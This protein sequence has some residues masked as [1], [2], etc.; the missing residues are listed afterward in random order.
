MI[1][2]IIAFLFF[3]YLVGLH[4]SIAIMEMASWTIA[5]LIL[6]WKIRS[7]EP[8]WFT[9]WRP[10]LA[11]TSVVG[12][13]LLMNPEGRPYID[14]IGFMRWILLM[15]FLSWAFD[16]VWNDAFERR[17][18]SFWVVAL[19]V[20]TSYAVFQC[21]TG[22]D[23]IR[24]QKEVLDPVG[25]L[26]RSTGFFSES[27]TYAYCTGYSL[28]A[29]ARPAF[30]KLEHKAWGWAAVIFGSAG[31]VVSMGRGAWLAL[32]VAGMLYVFFAY[33][34]AF[35]WAT[36]LLIIG[37]LGVGY[38]DSELANRFNNM[39]RLNIDHSN[40]MRLHLWRAYFEIWKDH[41]WFGVGLFQ[42][43]FLLPEYYSKLGIVEDFA[44]HSHNVLLGWLEGAGVFALALYVW[45]SFLFLRMAWNLREETPW[46]LSL[47][48]AQIF[49]HVGGL[50]ENNFF[51]G[52]VNHFQIFGWA[53]TLM[54]ARRYH[55]E[56]KP[57][58][59]LT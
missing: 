27:L 21:L 7:R 39:V 52:E 19:V 6:F 9:Y 32:I 8:V 36:A 50:T 42:G 34:R 55:S 16:L 11:L 25:N 22:I 46:G 14:Q 2:K 4:G 51:D 23:L 41:P 45:V 59:S 26:W 5:A 56:T 54:L 28:F 40:T 15:Y 13:S 48:F 35:V 38:L 49:L 58:F 18:I 53:L 33:R 30:D 1:T 20:A 29:I 24:P 37:G 31:I 12:V 10:L 3:A 44:G 57:S 17:F 43:D 47:F